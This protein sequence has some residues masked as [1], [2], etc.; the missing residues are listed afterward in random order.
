MWITNWSHR[1]CLRGLMAEWLLFFFF[2]LVQILLRGQVNLLET[3]YVI[4]T[5]FL[6]LY[7]RWDRWTEFQV[8]VME[9]NRQ[10]L[11]KQDDWS[12]PNKTIMNNRTNH[13]LNL[14]WLGKKNHDF[15]VYSGL[16]CY[17]HVAQQADSLARLQYMILSSV[18]HRHRLRWAVIPLVGPADARSL[19]PWQ[20]FLRVCPLL[21]W[22]G[23]TQ[24]LHLSCQKSSSAAHNPLCFLMSI[25][26][27]LAYNE[28][29]HALARQGTSEGVIPVLN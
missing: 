22:S 16:V 25:F 4:Q 21:A 1:S 5:Y 18:I 11:T 12:Y 14:S 6:S 8:K 10:T 3:W 23:P 13:F 19:R 17:F 29:I 26:F 20:F 9:I 7:I 27:C 24:D 15:H 2:R 28:F